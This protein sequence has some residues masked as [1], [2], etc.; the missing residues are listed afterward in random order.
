MSSPQIAF[1]WCLLIFLATLSGA[2][3]TSTVD[4]NPAIPSFISKDDTTVAQPFDL[5]Q[6]RLTDSIFK[7]NQDLDAKYILSLDPDRLLRNFRINANLPTK[8]VPLGGWEAPKCGLRGH[9]VGHYLSACGEMYAATGDLRF[10]DRGTYIV[11]EL[12][13]CQDAIG[14]GYLSAF[15][16]DAFDKLEKFGGGSW[17]PYYTIHKIMAGLLD[18]YHFCS[19]KQALQIAIKMADYFQGRIAKLDA[20]HIEKMFHTLG[21]GPQNEY[22]GMSEVLHNIY[23]LTKDSKYLILAEVFDRDWFLDPLSKQQDQ[24]SGLHVNTHVAQV[25]G[26]ARHYELT[27]DERCHRAAEYFW[28]QVVGHHSY[29]IGSTGKGEVFVP[30]DLE[31]TKLGFDTG[32]SCNV[33]NMLKLTEHIFSWDANL[34][35]ADY[36]EDALYNFILSSINPDTG[37]TTYFVS[38][39]PGHF[40]IYA[41]PETSFWCCTG[42]GIENHA[43]YGSGIYFHNA[44]SLWV[45][46]FIP[47]QLTWNEKELTLTQST[48]FPESDQTT[49]TIAAKKAIPLRI[50]LRIPYWTTT[51][52]NVRINGIAQSIKLSPG[53][54]LTLDRTWKTGDRIDL[55]LPMALHLHRTIDS[56]QTAAILYGPIVLA[57]D[58]GHTGMPPSDC[59]DNNYATFDNFPDPQVPVLPGDVLHLDSWIVPVPDEPLTFRT[60]GVAMDID[61]VPFYKIH[62]ERYSVYWRFSGLNHL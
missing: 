7:T 17:A 52:A 32:E 38:L 15:P 34:A 13:K 31:G 25:I 40:K 16:P 27:G 26:F 36:Y 18:Q 5:S 57:G 3:E 10:K 42:T 6:V 22:G 41:T 20:A 47:S 9:F 29:A 48:C 50:N 54:Y 11:T 53:S 2:G 12:G 8:A 61:L 55:T 44:D 1:R 56:P 24:L 49:L 28:S 23:A 21:H 46:L 14:S 35:A 45:N 51:E 39:K 19:N 59:T 33:Y 60:V 58:F 4:F 37:L 62:H 30:P 43:C